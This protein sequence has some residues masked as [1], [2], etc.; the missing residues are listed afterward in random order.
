MRGDVR[1]TLRKERVG[2]TDLTQNLATRTV[3]VKIRDAA[4]FDKAYE[5][6]AQAARCR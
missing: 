1:E 2:Y 4:D 3:S 6:L 5:E